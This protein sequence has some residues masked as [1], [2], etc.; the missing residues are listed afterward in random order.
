[1]GILDAP[2]LSKA[3]ADARYAQQNDLPGVNAARAGIDC[4]GATD[5]STA[6]YNLLFLT[7]NVYF[8]GT[9]KVNVVAGIGFTPPNNCKLSG[10]RPTFTMNGTGGGTFSGGSVINGLL[11]LAGCSGVMLA[12]FG[13]NN[14]TGNAIQ[15][16][17][18]FSD[19]QCDGLITNANNH[20]YL[21]E[22]FDADNTGSAQRGVHIYGPE[23]HG[24]PNGM[25]FK[26]RDVWVEDAIAHDIGVQCYVAVSDNIEAAGTYN[27]AQNVTFMN[28]RVG[29]R[30][31]QYG[32]RVYSRDCWSTTNANNVQPAK[33]IRFI[34]GDYSGAGN[35]GI[36]IGDEVTLETTPIAGSAAAGQTRLLSDVT[37]DTNCQ[38]NGWNGV[39]VAS[40]GS[41]RIRGTVGGNGTA[42]T[43]GGVNYTNN[44]IS[45][46]TTGVLQ[47]G[48]SA[49]QDMQISSELVV[50]GTAVGLEIQSLGIPAGATSVNVAARAQVYK[51]ANTGSVNLT[52][53]TGAVLGQEFWIEIADNFSIVSLA[54]NTP[55]Y[56]GNG[57]MVRYRC[58]D[59]SGTMLLVGAHEPLGKTEV[60]RSYNSAFSLNY[61]LGQQA[62]LVNVTGNITGI[63][64]FQPLVALGRDGY[65][66]RLVNSTAGAFTIAGWPAAIKWPTAQFPSGAPSSIA[67][68]THLL[69]TF[70]WDGA[71]MIAKGSWIY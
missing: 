47:Q 19:I 24:G 34:G 33:N 35:H 46:D 11:N 25:A 17:G 61:T 20:N 14:P 68:T 32:G 29:L 48:G 23:M 38:S 55:Q 37:I 44:N 42:G 36:M 50:K 4:T 69:L 64:L 21:F 31:A 54:T 6:L 5:V 18:G 59:T 2:G 40:C 16:V 30:C 12:R 28:C 53:V 22:Q 62:Q 65:S 70:F 1:M 56:M 67:A 27:R 45:A 41:V 7:R 10:I 57:T 8:T 58:V 39:R 3:T 63:T 71:S 9:I 51:T 66:L 15:A 52:S 26:C 43:V 60:V 13:V 49:V